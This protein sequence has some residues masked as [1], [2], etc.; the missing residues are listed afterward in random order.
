MR[1]N[2]ITAAIA[3]VVSQAIAQPKIFSDVQN[4]DGRSIG[5]NLVTFASYKKGFKWDMC[6]SYYEKYEDGDTTSVYAVGFDLSTRTPIDMDEDSRMLIKFDNDT[7]IET[8]V[9]H[10]LGPTDFH[11]KSTYGVVS[12]T[13]MP[14][15]ILTDA[16]M[17]YI[18]AHKIVKIRL[19]A[20]WSNQGYFDY[21]EAPHSKIWTPSETI[22]AF[23]K[24]IQKRL[25]EKPN[26]TIYDNF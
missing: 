12:Y 11:F 2:I 25:R 13:F 23:R 15:Y 17:D 8:T 6:M 9:L 7:I 14:F 22:A 21:Y 5:T 1:K 26:N 18:S 24:V 20:P 3:L 10:K 4:E 16:Q 19:E